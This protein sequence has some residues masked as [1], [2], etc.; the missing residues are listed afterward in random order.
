MN[1]QELYNYLHQTFEYKNGEL[2]Y[3]IQSG[4]QGRVGQ[5]AGTA[6]SNGYYQLCIKYKRYL[7]HRLIFL[8]HKKYLP[9]FIDHIDQNKSNNKIENLR[10]VTQSQNS[11]NTRFKGNQSNYR[12]VYPSGNKYRARVRLNKKIIDLGTFLTAELAYQAYCEFVKTNFPI[13]CLE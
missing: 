8:Y 7:T 2:Y 9:E 5:K 1:T 10:E 4:P 12:G 3:K 11:R 13:H 6:R